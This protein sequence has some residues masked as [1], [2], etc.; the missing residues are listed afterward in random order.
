MN[1]ILVGGIDI[2]VSKKKIKNMYIRVLPPDGIVHIAV[3]E[4][5]SDDALRMFAVSRIAWVKRQKQKFA[6][7]AR[8]TKRQYVSGES[9]YVW[10]R[11]YRLEVVYSAVRNAVYI[12]GNKLVLQ[13]RKESTDKQRENTLNEWYRD[14]LKLAIPPVLEKCEK[15]VGVRAAE[16]LVKNMRTK[17]G[18]CIPEHKRI[19]LNLQLAKKSPE[20]LEYVITHELVHM[21]ERNHSERFREYM[22][23]FYPTWRTVKDDLNSQPLDY[24]AELQMSD[25]KL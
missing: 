24:M 18:S 13:V 21:L 17:W 22:D 11:R 5:T 3:P 19:W 8:Q 23:K 6:D 10:G 9:Y 2:Q 7:Q 25:T 14:Q 4:D 1:H 12:S 16:W 20:C 15:I